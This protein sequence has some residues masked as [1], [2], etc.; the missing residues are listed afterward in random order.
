MKAVKGG[1]IYTGRDEPPIRD[2]FIIF[3]EEKGIVGISRKRNGA[4]LVGEADV[5][6]PAF[7]DGHSHIGMARAGEP[8]SE[9]ETNERMD[10]VLALVDALDSIYMDDRSFKESVEH[11]VLYSCVLPGSGN[12]IGG[13]GVVIRNYASTTEEA[14]IGYAGVK[15]ALG[16]NPRRTTDW[17]GTRPFTRMGAVAILRSTLL[18]ARNEMRL[19]EEGKKRLEEVDPSVAALF[20]ILKGEVKLRVHV[21]KPDDIMALLRIKREF[22]LNVVVDHAADVDKTEIFRRL[23]GERV[24]VVYGPVDAFAYK[25]ELKHESW[26]NIGKLVAA[27]PFYGLMTDHPV[28]LQRNL[29]LQLRFFRRFGLSKEACISIITWRNA[30]IL[31]VDNRLGTLEPGKWASLV[32]WSGDP[33]HL[34]SYP[35]MVIAEGRVIHE[36]SL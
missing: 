27:K 20:P 19:V 30:K 35:T 4:E 5:I 10:A 16:Y 28:I 6:T 29:F 13:K 9:S 3:D 33:F 14:F 2:A 26:R 23:A 22:G 1:V 36:E 24:P 18:K 25:T 34:D 12:V 32:L 15:A 31:G 11:G 8:S 21:H 7:I 17:K